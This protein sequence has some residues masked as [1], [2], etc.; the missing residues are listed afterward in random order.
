MNGM[1]G[2][3]LVILAVFSLAW[4]LVGLAMGYRL[5]PAPK[6]RGN[7]RRN[8]SRKEGRGKPRPQTKSQ[9]KRHSGQ[10]S[11]GRKGGGGEGLTELYVGNLSYDTT[12]QELRKLFGEYG[13]VASIRIIENR[14]NGKSKGFGFLEMASHKEA[15][16]AI[17]AMSGREIE[18]R[19]IV[20]NEAKSNAR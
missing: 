3:N 13:K 6:K 1:T 17:K 10:A 7:R 12:E 8:A 11:G 5:K 9:G 15:L 14:F 16:A 2:G 18:G 20:V 19:K 4:F